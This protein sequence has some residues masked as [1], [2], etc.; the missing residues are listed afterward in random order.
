MPTG[1]IIVHN[2]TH[3]Q[4]RS[5]LVNQTAAQQDEDSFMIIRQF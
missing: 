2:R 1:N 4:F 3:L 5:I